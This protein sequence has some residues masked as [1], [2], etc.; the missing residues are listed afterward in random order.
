MSRGPARW[1]RPEGVDPALWAYVQSPEVAAMEAAEESTSPLAALDRH[2]IKDWLRDYPTVVDLGCGTGRT[3]LQ[4][5]ELGHRVVAVDLAQAS[6]RRLADRMPADSPGIAIR[7]DI[8]RLD[9]LA[10]GRF[11]AAVLLYSTLGMIRGREN[12]RRV[13]REAAGVVRPGGLLIVHAHN[14]WANLHPSTLWPR[15]RRAGLS[16]RGWLD[17]LGDSPMRYAGIP[18]VTI[19]LY[20]WGELMAD[21]ASTAWAYVEVLPLG[22]NS[23]ASLARPRFCHSWRADGWLIR[24]LRRG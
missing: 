10:P 4:L 14:F 12:R 18:D 16:R 21:L 13:L 5:L 24:A 2:I 19:H 17:R 9:L 23:A 1:R 22:R 3:T 7:A 11:D 20:R 6:L 15:L 8:G